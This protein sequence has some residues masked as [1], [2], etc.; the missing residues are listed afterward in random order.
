MKDLIQIPIF[1]LS[2]TLPHKLVHWFYWDYLQRK[3][4]FIVSVG[5]RYNQKC[6]AHSVKYIS[7]LLF[8][9]C[10]WGLSH[11]IFTWCFFTLDFG[12]C[13]YFLSQRLLTLISKEFLSDYFSVFVFLGHY[14]CRA[15]LNLIFIF[16]S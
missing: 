3:M 5:I 9:H 12:Y 16:N 6:L 13:W 4:L 15:V 2:G 14:F 7:V 8:M 11:F 10:Y 1:K